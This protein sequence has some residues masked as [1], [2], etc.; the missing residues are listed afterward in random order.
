ME[1]EDASLEETLKRL[2]IYVVYES[3]TLYF[4]V[5]G[6]VVLFACNCSQDSNSV[7]FKILEYTV[8]SC[9]LMDTYFSVFVTA[10]FLRPLSKVLSDGRTVSQHSQGYKQLQK[11]KY[12]TLFGSSLA[13]MSSSMLYVLLLAFFDGR[14]DT[15][16]NAIWLNPLIIG[17]HV[18]AILGVCSGEGGGGKIFY[19]FH[20]L[21][22]YIAGNL[23]S[24]LNDFGMLF[25]CGFFKHI[26]WK[27][28]K[29]FFIR[30]PA[31]ADAKTT[32]NNIPEFA[33][34]SK[35]YD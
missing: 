3:R 29:G 7:G 16:Q 25:V 14:T 21:S 12:N 28:F 23:D 8:L 31:V 24:I 1:E 34:D 11:T 15:V 35:A 27:I 10:I 20:L 4:V 19:V 17:N 22:L 6:V 13:V 9:C 30:R 26:N 33:I 2:E 32:A 18:A 5:L